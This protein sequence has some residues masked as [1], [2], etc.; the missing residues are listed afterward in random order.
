[1]NIEAQARCWQQRP[2]QASTPPSSQPELLSVEKPPQSKTLTPPHSPSIPALSSG[3]EIVIAHF[4]EDLEWLGPFVSSCHVYSKG[5]PVE[6][7]DEHSE[8]GSSAIEQASPYKSLQQLPNIGRETHTYLTYITTHYDDLPPYMLLLQGDIHS[9]NHGTPAHTDLTLSEI[10]SS[11]T[12]L[13]P[14][15]VLPIGAVMEFS[16]WQGLVYKQGWVERR[17]KTLVRSKL[18]P[19]EYWKTMFSADSSEQS[20]TKGHPK[21]VRFVQGACFGV[22]KDAILHRPRSF[23]LNV[24]RYF[25]ELQEC[26]PEEGHYMERLWYS[27]LDPSVIER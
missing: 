23:W 21:S 19:G 14:G 22:T 6:L 15:G 20:E 11:T 12:Q 7:A 5:E 4:N 27:L 13:A 24:L 9:I 3:V 1:M 10:I 8:C 2:R 17:G 25:E 18:T 16:D 26:N